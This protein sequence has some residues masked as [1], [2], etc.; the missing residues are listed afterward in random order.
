MLRKGTKILQK[1]IW[2]IDSKI[3]KRIWKRH[4]G[5]KNLSKKLTHKIHDKLFNERYLNIHIKEDK[6]HKNEWYIYAIPMEIK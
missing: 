2:Q 4:L 1:T 3:A 5:R 6:T